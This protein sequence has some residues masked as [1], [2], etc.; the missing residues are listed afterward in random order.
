MSY[1]KK[2][3]ADSLLTDYTP[4]EVRASRLLSHT[5]LVTIG[6]DWTG[7]VQLDGVIA[8]LMVMEQIKSYYTW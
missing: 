8:K 3:K 7:L 5:E 2:V 4:P 1:R 6:P